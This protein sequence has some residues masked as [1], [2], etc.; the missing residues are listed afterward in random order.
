MQTEE[1][2]DKSRD[3]YGG[4]ALYLSVALIS[5]SVLIVEIS[6]TR[7]FSVM[8]SYH[9]VFL[10]VSLAILG[11]GAG[12]IYVHKRD[13]KMDG[14]GVNQNILTLSSGL[15]ALSILGMTVLTMKVAL[16]RT[17]FSA[18]ALTFLPFFF[19]GIFLSGSFWLFPEKST[20]IYAADLIGAGLGS[21]LVIPLLKLGGINVLLMS[22]FVA[23]LPALL[24]MIRNPFGKGE[25]ST[26]V[27]LSTVLLAILFLNYSTV[28]MGKIPLGR[29]AHK[30]MYH[31]MTNPMMGA[32]V[33][34]SRWSAFG[35][36]DLI[37]Y[38]NNLTV[39]DL[40]LDGTAGTGVYRFNGNIRDLNRPEFTHFP[41]Y[42]PFE[43]LSD[44]EKEKVLIIG[45]GGGREVLI[46]LLGGAKEMTAVEV[47]GD[48]VDLMR[49]YSDFNGGIYNSFPDV[50]VVVGEGRNFVRRGKEQFDIIMLAIP[51][52]KTSRSPEAFVLTENYLFTVESINDYLDRLTSEGRL[53]VVAHDDEEIF[54]LIFTSLAAMEKRG[55]DTLS[56][57]KHIYT[58]G[59]EYFPVFVLKKS[60]LTPAEAQGVHLNMHTHEYSTHSSFIPFIEQAKRI[61]PMGE[62]IYREQEMLNQALYL[63]A[64]G[65]VSPE[66]LIKAAS[67]EAREVTDDA[68]FFYKI[69]RGMPPV[70]VLLLIFSSITMILVWMIKPGY[71]NER[72]NPH[73]NILL[74][75]LFSL[76]GTGFMLI[77]IPLIQKFILFLGQPVYSMAALL[78]SLLIGAG[79]GSWVG[80]TFWKRRILYKLRLA[81]IMVGILAGIY[82]LFLPHVFALLLG[83]SF[84][85]RI[86]MSFVL[87]SPLGFFM[88]M[89]FPL[90]MR[91]LGEMGLTRYIPRMW[92]VNGI[93]SVL[94][95]GLAI[96]LAISFG[97]SYAMLLG[98]I[99]YFSIFFLFSFRFRA[100][101]T[102]LP[103]SSYGLGT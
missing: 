33:I 41:G 26:S 27:I 96:A 91:L 14:R 61:I 83:S 94:G 85:S 95:S 21:L 87:L 28:F 25:G 54:R 31:V 32:K 73:N 55:I 81:S 52:T 51:V 100:G 78:F 6:L 7:V 98:A 10:L 16:L 20:K 40:F 38:E 1:W 11:L 43:L 48:L 22:A 67:F 2:K 39:M 80:G 69:D 70:I 64:Q 34:D 97:F 58:V 13:Q 63:M 101:N 93:G 102:Y 66:E 35:R 59:P 57:M 47:N 12:G 92:G 60:P 79:I 62:G 71:T 46:S 18:A 37:A 29:G 68:P 65:K 9:Y 72:D 99:L 50:K 76:L 36:T 49:E 74:L 23:S 45:S 88:G 86:L 5:L 17:V 90:G 77:E 75:L 4:W 53:I 89:P 30:E 56:A 84:Y 15:M 8:F 103:Q 3:G 44:W 82:I 24:L 42:F 19:G